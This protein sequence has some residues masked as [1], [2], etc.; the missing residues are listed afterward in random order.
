STIAV[1]KIYE[2]WFKLINY[3]LYSPNLIPNDFFLFPRLKVRL[4][5]H[6][7]S[8]NENTDIDWHK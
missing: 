6:R 4:G 2:L 1:T 8:S 3:L 7:F 5:G